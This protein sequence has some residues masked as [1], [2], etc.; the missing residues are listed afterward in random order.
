MQPFNYKNAQFEYE[1]YPICYIPS[2]L[3]AADYKNLSESYPS[4]EVFKYKPTLGN[5]YSL[6]E[7]NNRQFY[8]DFLQ[9]N[10]DW[11][12][13]Y[14]IIKTKE[15]IKEALAFVRDH[16]IDLNIKRFWYT[17]RMAKTR[18]GPIARIANKY[19]LRS[20]F[21]FSIMSANGG[22]ILPHTDHPRKLITLVLSFM[23]PGEWNPAWGGGT[24]VLK[25]KDRSRTYNNVNFQLPFDQVDVV[26]TFPFEPNQCVLFIKTYNSWHSVQPMTGPAEALRKTVT[27][28]IENII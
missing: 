19:V 24:D 1:P 4:L 5:K 22:N 6:A 9:A 2:F 11:R 26:K 13:F 16:H 28:N 10:P 27:I 25:P 12:E 3:H 23:K 20:R 8:Y 15:F 17:G 7:K 18:R 21:E 14:N